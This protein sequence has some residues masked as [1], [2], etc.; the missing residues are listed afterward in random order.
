M[1]R[2]AYSYNMSHMIR[3]VQFTPV[4]FA[5]P[6]KSLEILRICDGL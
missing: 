4:Q 3:V 2:S 1:T 6:Q 5:R